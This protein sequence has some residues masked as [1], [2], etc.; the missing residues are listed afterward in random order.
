MSDNTAFALVASAITL[1]FTAM[2]ILLIFDGVPELSNKVQSCY[3]DKPDIVTVIE[4]DRCLVWRVWAETKFMYLVKCADSDPIVVS[5]FMIQ[6][7]TPAAISQG[8]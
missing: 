3:L 2:L 7:L 6:P 8:N 1:S 4:G 5:D